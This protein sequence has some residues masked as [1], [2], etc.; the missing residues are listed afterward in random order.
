MALTRVGRNFTNIDCGPNGPEGN[1][2]QRLYLFKKLF[3]FSEAENKAMLKSQTEP[4]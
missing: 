3:A 4:V 2:R 1:Y